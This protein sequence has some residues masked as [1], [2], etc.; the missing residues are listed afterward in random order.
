M[1]LVDFFV[2]LVVINTLFFF[3]LFPIFFDNKQHIEHI[4]H[5]FLIF[6]HFLPIVLYTSFH[7]VAFVQVYLQYQQMVDL[8]FYQYHLL[9]H[10]EHQVHLHQSLFH[11]LLLGRM[12]FDLEFG[13]AVDLVLALVPELQP[14]QQLFVLYV[15]Q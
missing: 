2:V 11:L 14:Q 4:L 6:L 8:Y 12:H 13:L 7:N 9:N 5:H 3:L 1:Q 15:L 10:L